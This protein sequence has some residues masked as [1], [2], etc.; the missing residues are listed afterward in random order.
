MTGIS[1]ALAGAVTIA[2]VSTIGDFIWANWLPEHRGIYGL[3]HGTV[4]FLSIGAV[5]GVVGATRAARV[6]RAA[7]GALAGGIVGLLGAGAFYLL[8]PVV[9]FSAMFVVWFGT[10]IVL[11]WV[12][13]YLSAARIDR[14]HLRDIRIDRR[15]IL[16]RGIVAAIASALAFYS[17]SG[18]WRPFNPQGWDYLMHFG[19]WTLAYFPGF[20]ALLVARRQASDAVPSRAET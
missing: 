7:T 19:A 20:A 9:G 6:R 13:G 16:T 5:L 17:I 8:S 11:A 2:V 4:L 10:W 1:T 12:Y 15:A 3:I 18:I 14:G